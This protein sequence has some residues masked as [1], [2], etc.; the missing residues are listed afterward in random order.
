MMNFI[1]WKLESCV[2]YHLWVYFERKEERLRSC[3]VWMII[4]KGRPRWF[5]HVERDWIK[6]CTAME[7]DG[8]RQKGT[9]E[10]DMVG[11]WWRGYEE[12]W[13]VPGWCTGVEQ[14][15]KDSQEVS[16][17]RFI[18]KM[19]CTCVCVQ[20]WNGCVISQS[21]R[22]LWSVLLWVCCRSGALECFA[23]GVL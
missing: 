1:Y 21:G 3:W 22:E 8:T 6:H 13:T 4:Q 23:P 5:G 7:R 14:M 20:Q 15:E 19:L 9:P 11:W 16:Q 12:I 18:W 17:P 10:K 2:C